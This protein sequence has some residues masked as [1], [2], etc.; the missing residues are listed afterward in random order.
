M[1]GALMDLQGGR[2]LFDRIAITISGVHAEKLPFAVFGTQAEIAGLL[3]TT[4]N[5]RIDLADRAIE[6]GSAGVVVM[7]AGNRKER[8]PFWRLHIRNNLVKHVEDVS[9]ALLHRTGIV[10]VAEVNNDVGAELLEC[11][12]QQRCIIRHVG[13]PVADHQ[14]AAVLRQRIVDDAEIDVCWRMRLPIVVAWRQVREHVVLRVVPAA[15]DPARDI[16]TAVL[17]DESLQ[18][19]E[20]RTVGRGVVVLMRLK[21]VKRGLGTLGDIGGRPYR[22][23]AS[24]LRL[25]TWLFKLLAPGVFGLGMQRNAVFSLLFVVIGEIA[26]VDK[27]FTNCRLPQ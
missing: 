27:G 5:A 8:G 4:R 11:L 7:I 2:L 1:P 17:C 16:P 9:G 19:R 6:T 21:G 12:T 3:G 13:T 24:G 18:R 10:D 25:R 20:K 23:L 26:A 15:L 14:D 22:R